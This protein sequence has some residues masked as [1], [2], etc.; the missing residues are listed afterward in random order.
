MNKII[1]VLSIVV[2][3]IIIITL[4][5]RRSRR[6]NIE[7]RAGDK[8]RE[9]ALDKMILNDKRERDLSPNQAIPFE[10]HYDTENQKKS[11]KKKKEAGRGSKMM[12]QITEKNHISARKYMLAPSGG[13]Y[14]GSKNGENHI[15]VGNST[16]VDARQCEIIES[17]DKAY[18]HNLGTSG[19][20]LLSRAGNRA[21]VEQKYIEL[22]SGDI[23]SLGE[24]VLNIEIIK[25]KR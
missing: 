18:V 19:R 25:S 8:M 9:E 4:L 3:L 12:L 2:T 10:V 23:L 22:K 13:I 17:G 14:I 5:K 24:S 15:V 16:N 21:Y 20:V 6:K 1:I 11:K 7:Q